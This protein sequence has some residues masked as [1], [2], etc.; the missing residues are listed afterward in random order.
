V[1]Y[2]GGWDH[3]DLIPGDIVQFE[4]SLERGF[5]MAGRVTSA[6]GTTLIADADVTAVVGDSVAITQSDGTIHETTVA[7]VTSPTQIELT[8]TLTG[9]VLPNSTF[10]VADQTIGKQLFRVIKV[11]EGETGQFATIL[12]RFSPDKYNKI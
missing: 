12:Q 9:T 1:S 3:Y 8:D 4:D 5:R 7:S 6:T 11:E 10:I 2:I